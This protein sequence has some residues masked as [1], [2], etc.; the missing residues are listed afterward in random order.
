MSLWELGA[1]ACA[2]AGGHK[3]LWSSPVGLR[4][5]QER[6]LKPFNIPIAHV[7]NIISLKFAISSPSH[8]IEPH[9]NRVVGQ[10][11]AVP[12]RP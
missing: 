12:L 9:S 3:Y 10:P 6:R 2:V 4:V 8:F 11:N 5:V 7:N 1:G